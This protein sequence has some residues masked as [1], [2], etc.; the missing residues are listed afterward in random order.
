MDIYSTEL[1]M[2]KDYIY[3]L[4][5]FNTI[6]D[7]ENDTVPTYNNCSNI[8]IVGDWIYYIIR[9]YEYDIYKI[10]FDGKYNEPIYVRNRI[11]FD[12]I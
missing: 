12:L 7:G 8:N 3:I 6:K 1:F 10:S 5:G 11:L 9:S 2:Y 4:S